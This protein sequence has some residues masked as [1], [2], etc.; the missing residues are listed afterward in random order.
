MRKDLQ[1]TRWLSIAIGWAI[2]LGAAALASPAPLPMY[3]DRYDRDAGLSQLAVHTIAQDAT[4]F[5]WL[6]TEDGLDRF[7]GYTFTHSARHT[8][9]PGSL[10][11]GFVADVQPDASGA[12]W[13][14]TD[15]GGVARQNPVTGR[16]EP[17]P[18][19]GPAV[20]RAGLERV[21]CLLFDHAGQLWIGTRDEGLAR[22][23]PRSRRIGRLRHASG[24]AASLASDSIFA[25]LEDRQHTMWI[26]T[27]EGLDR[28]E[29][30]AHGL[31]RQP[32]PVPQPTA[33]R[34]LLEDRS[35][36]LWAGT[37]AGLVRLDRATR[38]TRLFRHDAADASSLPADGVNAL[39]EDRAGRLW[40][41][42]VSG[43]ALLDA[44]RGT[45]SV[46]KHDPADPRSLPDDHIV[47][48]HEDRGGLIWVG[49]KFG[50]LA[51]PCSVLAGW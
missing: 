1:Q 48:L 22:F 23:D 11:N 43:L 17:L 12:L 37:T 45:F 32:L 28:I 35:G 9:E 13:I 18:T 8:D 40:I 16:F 7:D 31:T 24:D 10:P 49:T 39:L 25:L 2:A 46:Y 19:P 29:A 44:A 21:R 14:A 5:I 41:G 33:V 42:T 38:A 4:G 26:G 47:S 20:A 34:A 30:G 3:F 36:A 50:G 15:G 27:A 6:G 51:K